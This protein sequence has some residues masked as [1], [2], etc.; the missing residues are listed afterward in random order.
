MANKKGRLI[1]SD[2]DVYDGEWLNDKA[3]GKGVYLHK[4]GS[5]YEGEWFEDK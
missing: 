4:E 1:H 5:S 2:G 3:H